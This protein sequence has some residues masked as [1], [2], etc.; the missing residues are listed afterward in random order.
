MVVARFWVEDSFLGLLKRVVMSRFK[1][2][3]LYWIIYCS[4]HNDASATASCGNRLHF[5]KSQLHYV[6][7]FYIFHIHNEL[8][9]FIL[10]VSV[11]IHDRPHIRK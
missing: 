5:R 8:L 10:D 11:V 3:F 9:P 2:L 6:K 7:K 4:L 1:L